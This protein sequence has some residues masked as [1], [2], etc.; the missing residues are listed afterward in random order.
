[1]HLFRIYIEYII[2]IKNEIIIKKM[3]YFNLNIKYLIRKHIYL[4]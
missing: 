2:F 4:I 3:Y 1:M